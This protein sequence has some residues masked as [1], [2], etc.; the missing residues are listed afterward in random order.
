VKDVEYVAAVPSLLSTG[1]KRDLLEVAIQTDIPTLSDN[2]N[3]LMETQTQ[4]PSYL[5]PAVS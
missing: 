3:V 1:V 5:T 4:T 2:D